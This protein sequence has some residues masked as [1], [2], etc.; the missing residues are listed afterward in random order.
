MIPA[1]LDLKFPFN[2]TRD[3]EDAVLLGSKTN[4]RDQSY[5]LLEQVK[6][7]L[8]LNVQKELQRKI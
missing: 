7:K 8:H 4:T 5:I 3:Q 1:I 2:L 6:P